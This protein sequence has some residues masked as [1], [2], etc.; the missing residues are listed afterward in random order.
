M[1]TFGN[2]YPLVYTMHNLRLA[3]K[4]AR[5][6]KT[7]YTW[8]KRVDEN[9]KK[10]LRRLGRMLRHKDYT[11]SPY[12]EFMLEDRGKLREICDLPYFPDR[13]VHWALMLQVEPILVSTFI[14]TSYAAIPGRGA[15]LALQHLTDCL[16]HDPE[17]TQYCLKLDVHKFFPS[18]DHDILKELMRRKIKCKDTLWLLDEVIDSYTSVLTGKGVPIGN[19]TSQYFG[20]F[21]LTYFDHWLKETVFTFTN[22]EGIT[23]IRQVHY[24]FRYMDDMVI[25]SDSKEF[26]QYLLGQIQW[27]LFTYLRLTLK[28]NYQ[29]FPVDIRGIDFVGYRSFRDYILLR[30]TTKKRL[31][32]AM[33]KIGKCTEKY[34]DL[35]EHQRC[36]VASYSGVLKWCD[37]KRLYHKNI[38]RV[39]K[40][41]QVI[42]KENDYDEIF[43]ERARVS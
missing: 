15:H 30:T 24:Y 20:N 6:G 29:V 33:K 37:G 23:E 19:Y 12:R 25:L 13:I 36:V 35:T 16:H 17:G 7:S 41:M 43:Y 31:K 18:I 34:H 11:T 26:L 9:P 8:V 14:N 27:Y 38:Y 22:S 40:H 39:L 42:D 10:Y 3:H 4:K 21:Y 32:R 28:D 2:I 5:K 1:K